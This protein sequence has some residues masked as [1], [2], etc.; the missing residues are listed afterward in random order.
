[1][2]GN[3]VPISLIDHCTFGDKREKRESCNVGVFSGNVTGGMRVPPIMRCI[4]GIEE[5]D[6]AFSAVLS[7]VGTGCFIF[8]P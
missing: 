6:E 3:E 1:M 8:I 7:R 2:S 5:P 4:V